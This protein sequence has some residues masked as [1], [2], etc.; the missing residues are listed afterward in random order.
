M[1]N[2]PYMNAYQYPNY[3]PKYHYYNQSINWTHHHI[4]GYYPGRSSNMLTDYGPNPFVININEATKQN[5]TFRT[6][7][8]TGAQFQI[9]LMSLNPGEDIGLEM[10]PDVDQFLRLEQGRGIVQMGK[11]KDNL[12]FQRYVYDDSAIV[13]PAGTWHNLTNTGSTPLK[14][15][16][17]YAPPNHPFGT[18]HVTKTDA[19]AAEEGQSHING[20]TV[21]FGRTPDDWIRYTEFLVNEGLEDVKRGINVTHILQEFILM[22][23]LV[24]KGYS[25]EKAYETVEEWERTGESKL[26]QQSKNM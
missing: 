20:N 12:S 23:V 17:I 22:G 15:Y 14:L 6:A 3:V 10:H 25:P 5:N 11:T 1:Y 16:S 7:L 4:N 19:M 18:V 24:G 2:D 26:L 21:I 9:T 8:W 13:I